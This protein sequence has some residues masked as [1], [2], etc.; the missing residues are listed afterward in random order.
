MGLGR[1]RVG[2]DCSSSC[3]SLP[4]L[5]PRRAFF[6]DPTGIVRERFLGDAGGG[7][8]GRVSSSE[9]SPASINS[10]SSSDIAAESVLSVLSCLSVCACA[11]PDVRVEL[12]WMWMW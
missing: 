10:S 11:R 2:T 3:P 6:L 4:E 5:E 9:S 7:D 8:D 12:R 1:G